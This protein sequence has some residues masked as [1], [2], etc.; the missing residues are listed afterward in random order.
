MPDPF[1]PSTATHWPAASLR[2]SGCSAARSP[3][4]RLTPDTTS[5][6]GRAG[7]GAGGGFRGGTGGGLPGGTGG[8]F[9]GGTG[10]GFPGGTGGGLPG[11]TG[12]GLPDGGFWGGTVR[13]HHSGHAGGTSREHPPDPDRPRVLAV[14]G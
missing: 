13:V 1:A 4:R 11:G 7:R 14:R 3:Y 9:P 6:G 8:G 12:G 5:S 10:G 2:S